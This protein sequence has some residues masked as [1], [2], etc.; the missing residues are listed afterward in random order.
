MITTAVFW[1]SFLTPD[2]LNMKM[3]EPLVV[4]LSSTRRLLP[5]RKGIGATSKV[6]KSRTT[7]TNVCQLLWLRHSRIS[8]LHIRKSS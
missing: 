7:V 2:M 8:Y 5:P 6:P 4:C 1:L 3:Q